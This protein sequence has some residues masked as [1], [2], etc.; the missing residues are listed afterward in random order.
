MLQTCLSTAPLL[1][2]TREA[3]RLLQLSLAGLSTA[4]KLDALL[5]ADGFESGDTSAWTSTDDLSLWPA[6]LE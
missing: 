4:V 2:G 6:T 5:L 3:A 1:L